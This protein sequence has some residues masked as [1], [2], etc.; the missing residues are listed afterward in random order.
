MWQMTVSKQNMKAQFVMTL[1][2]RAT[3]TAERCVPMR[4]HC[5]KT[6]SKEANHR[7]PKNR[8]SLSSVLPE[9]CEPLLAFLKVVSL[10]S[11]QEANEKEQR[12][13][14]HLRLQLI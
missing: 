6:D 14:D 11:A 10:E 8:P 5:N 4:M 12:V 3:R 2:S 1:T 13:Y 7:K 9:P